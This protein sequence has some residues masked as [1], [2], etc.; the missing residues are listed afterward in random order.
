MEK[1]GR[2]EVRI[3]RERGGTDGRGVVEGVR[4]GES[5]EWRREK[6]GGRRSEGNERAERK[7][8]LK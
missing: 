3:G 1:E 5:G 7:R 6:R 4:G 2:R 8:R